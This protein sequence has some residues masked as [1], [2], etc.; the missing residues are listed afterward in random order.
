MLQKSCAKI[1][2][3][4]YL[5]Y[6]IFNTMDSLKFIQKRGKDPLKKT[7]E[8]ARFSLSWIRKPKKYL[9][10]LSITFLTP[11]SILYFKSSFKIQEERN[12]WRKDENSTV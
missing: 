4:I 7:W 8:V 5:G 11:A 9:S 6:K 3:N 1:L 12:D 10:R 2:K